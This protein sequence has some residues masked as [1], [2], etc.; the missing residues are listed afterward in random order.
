MELLK[1]ILSKFWKEAAIVILCGLCL[2]LTYGRKPEIEIRE[3]VKIEEKVVTKVETVVT[4]RERMKEKTRVTTKPNGTRVEERII[5]VQRDG[6]ATQNQSQEAERTK[7]ESK[8]MVARDKKT[9]YLLGLDTNLA[10]DSVGA[11]LGM[12]L[13]DTPIFATGHVNFKLEKLA[14]PEVRVGLM[15]EF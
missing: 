12:R 14:S 7:E 5:T 2:V 10:R 6:A 11:G 8:S 4:W 15:L 13:A 1:S 9:R 3:V